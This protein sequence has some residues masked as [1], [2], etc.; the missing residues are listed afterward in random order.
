MSEA[1][2]TWRIRAK[3]RGIKARR[4]LE[5]DPVTPIFVSIVAIFFIMF[6]IIPII[7]ILGNS[8]YYDSLRY[9]Y[10]DDNDQIYSTTILNTTIHAVGDFETVKGQISNK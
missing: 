1:K 4:A 3:N 7:S 6:L 8:V 2:P 10:V 5:R 9:K